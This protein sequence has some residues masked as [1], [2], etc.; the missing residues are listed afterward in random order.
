MTTSQKIQLKLYV[1]GTTKTLSTM[2]VL[3]MSLFPHK[4][5]LADSGTESTD[6]GCREHTNP[7]TVKFC[8][9]SSYSM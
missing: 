2:A 5:P 6:T 1:V 3:E 9:P 4:W 7:I 8:L